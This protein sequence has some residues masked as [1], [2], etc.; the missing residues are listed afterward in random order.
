MFIWS[1]QSV[2]PTQVKLFLGKCLQLIPEYSPHPWLSRQQ[3]FK[4]PEW[5]TAVLVCEREDKFLFSWNHWGVWG[6]VEIFPEE[7]NFLSLI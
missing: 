2:L 7:N 3:L 5:E 4:T 6:W 1:L